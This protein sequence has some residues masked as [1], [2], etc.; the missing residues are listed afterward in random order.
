MSKQDY[1]T[2]WPFM[3]ALAAKL[4]E[5]IA[6]DL[7]ASKHNAKHERYFTEADDSL[8]QDWHK[9]DGLLF[10]NPPFA[11]ARPW[12]KKCKDESAKGARIASLTLASVGSEWFAEHVYGNARV[13]LLRPRIKFDGMAPNP[14]TGKVDPFIKDCMV[15]IWDRNI[16]PR[17]ELWDWSAELAKVAA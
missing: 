9:I 1:G 2:P 7:A 13:L 3:D 5:R 17:I 12:M 6:F 4:G 11:N 8:V 15:C 10:L 16:A 14:R